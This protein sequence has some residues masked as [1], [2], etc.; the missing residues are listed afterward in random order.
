MPGMRLSPITPNYSLRRA[1][2]A[3]IAAVLALCAAYGL[4]LGVCGLMLASG[5]AA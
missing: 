5:L 3:C 1:V 2:A 4:F